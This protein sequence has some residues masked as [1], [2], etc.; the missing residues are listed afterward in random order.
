MPFS[1]KRNQLYRSD[2]NIFPYTE[3]E[4]AFEDSFEPEMS[5]GNYE[6]IHFTDQKTMGSNPPLYYIWYRSYKYFGN[7]NTLKNITDETI[8]AIK[9]RRSAPY[10]NALKSE[11][12]MILLGPSFSLFSVGRVVSECD[13]FVISHGLVSH[14][15]RNYF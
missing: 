1:V 13:K 15:Y 14:L 12:K 2:E 7:N 11:P 8:E 6:Y 10:V 9:G 4:I 3:T 5:Y